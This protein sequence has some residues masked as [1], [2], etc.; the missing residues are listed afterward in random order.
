MN[1]AC[2]IHVS[3]T[4]AATREMLLGEFVPGLLKSS[5]EPVIYFAD[6]GTCKGLGSVM[7][8]FAAAGEGRNLAEMMGSLVKRNSHLKFVVIESPWLLS[9]HLFS[10]GKC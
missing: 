8:I 9:P 7:E 10:G 3:Y 4:D 5:S 1:G 6:L 2:C